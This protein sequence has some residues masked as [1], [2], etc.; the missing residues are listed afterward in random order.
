MGHVR[1]LIMRICHISTS[2]GI[3]PEGILLCGVPNSAIKYTKTTWIRKRE[4]YTINLQAYDM[5]MCP[6]CVAKLTVYDELR[7]AL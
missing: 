1:T 3:L 7:Y 6:D 2:I 4:Y 5:T